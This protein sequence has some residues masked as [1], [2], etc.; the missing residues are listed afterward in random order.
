MRQLS[1]DPPLVEEDGAVYSVVNTNSPIFSSVEIWNLQPIGEEPYAPLH[2]PENPVRPG[3]TYACTTS[4]FFF[5]INEYPRF[6]LGFGN[7]VEVPISKWAPDVAVSNSTLK[8]D[9]SWFANVE[10]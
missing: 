5:R 8:V 4:Y 2:R 6:T 1:I 9:R 10:S 3:A 7:V